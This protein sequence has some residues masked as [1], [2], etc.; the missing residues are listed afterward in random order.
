MAPPSRIR[1]LMIYQSVKVRLEYNTTRSICPSKILGFNCGRARLK[2][3]RGAELSQVPI[4][5]ALADRHITQESAM[6]V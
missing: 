6:P 5:T 4:I 3:G 2:V 1:G